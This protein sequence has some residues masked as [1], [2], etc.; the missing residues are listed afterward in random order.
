MSTDKESFVH[1]HVH[2]EFSMLDGAARIKPLI[3]EVAAQGMPAIGISDHGNNHGAF[4]FYKTAHK[5]ET[6][7]ELTSSSLN[8]SF[9]SDNDRSTARE[10]DA[11]RVTKFFS[12]EN[13][14]LVDIDWKAKA[15][16]MTLKSNQSATLAEQRFTW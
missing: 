9:G 10:P 16:T 4:D 3:Q 7:W 13:Y 8:L 11:A 2:T 5:G 15:L 14:G 1:L 12:E 6:M